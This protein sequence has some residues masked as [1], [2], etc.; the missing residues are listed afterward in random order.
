LP[1][2]KIR[3]EYIFYIFEGKENFPYLL[4]FHSLNEFAKKYDMSLFLIARICN[5]EITVAL[6]ESV[7]MLNFMLKSFS[8]VLKFAK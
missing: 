6:I 4:F 7:K 3:I 8:W 5:V 2:E 1:C